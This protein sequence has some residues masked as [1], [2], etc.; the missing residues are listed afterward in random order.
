ML[1][2]TEQNASVQHLLDPLKLTAAT[3]IVG[4]FLFLSGANLLFFN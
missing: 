4:F 3:N 2:D 1:L